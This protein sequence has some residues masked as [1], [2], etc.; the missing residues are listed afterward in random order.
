MAHELK[1]SERKEEERVRKE[2]REEKWR[3]E[4]AYE[5]LHRGL[6]E[7]DGEGLGRSNQEE[8]DEDDFM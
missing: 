2:Q 1:K 6:G 5:E 7:D 3:R 8:S 4:H